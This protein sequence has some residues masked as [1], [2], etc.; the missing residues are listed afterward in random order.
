M[1]WSSKSG[2]IYSVRVWTKSLSPSVI[3]IFMRHTKNM[4]VK[5]GEKMSLRKLVSAI[6]AFA[7][8]S[9]SFVPV[10]AVTLD[11]GVTTLPV[12]APDVGTTA[13]GAN[14]DVIPA[15]IRITASGTEI[16]Y[17]TLSG[18]G[19]N[20]ASAVSVSANGQLSTANGA[21]ALS[22]V[23]R[24]LVVTP[25]AGTKFVKLASSETGENYLPA[26]VTVNGRLASAAA[27]TVKNL[28]VVQNPAAAYPGSGDNG[29]AI[30]AAVLTKTGPASTFGTTIAAG[31]V[32][33]YFVT[34][35]GAATT[36]VGGTM[37]V[38]LAGIG[39][40]ADPAASPT[41]SGTATATFQTLSGG[42]V[43]SAISGAEGGTVNIGTYGS[44]AGK[45]E[46]VMVGDKTGNET[47]TT[48]EPDSQNNS[49]LGNLLASG[50]STVVIGPGNVTT[51]TSGATTLKV[52]TDALVLRAAERNDSSS[53]TFKFYET[54]FATS[55]FVSSSPVNENGTASI[56]T[57][58][59]ALTNTTTF[60]N[61]DNAL[62]TVKFHA[63]KPGTTTA[64]SA[65]MVVNAVSV[66]LVGPRAF[67]GIRG[68]ASSSK[69]GSTQSLSTTAGNGGFLGAVAY[70][71][72]NGNTAINS[73]VVA[74]SKLAI[75]V[76]YNG[77]SATGRLTMKDSAPLTFTQQLAAH[78]FVG[79]T[80][81]VSALNS[82]S[83][84]TLIHNGT[85]ANGIFPGALVIGYNNGGTANPYGLVKT[86]TDNGT[87]FATFKN[88]SVFTASV[89][90]NQAIYSPS[91]VTVRL[92]NSAGSSTN[93]NAW[94][95][96]AGNEDA[97]DETAAAGSFE[98]GGSNPSADLYSN[99]AVVKITNGNQT[100]KNARNNAILVAR[101]A[102]D[103]L[104]IL[105]ITDKY[106][107]YRDAIAIRPEIT[108]TLD[109]T[110]KAE[111][112]DV[113][114]VATG[115]NLSGSTSKTVARVLAAG[116]VTTNATV[117][118]LPVSGNLT[119]LM[120]ESS[121]AAGTSRASVA[122]SSITGAS[123]SVDTVSDLASTGLVIDTT[124]PPLFCGGTAGTGVKGPNGVV[125]QPK[126]RAVLIT[127][128]GADT[129]SDMIALGSNTVIRVTLPTG[130]DLN[131]YNASLASSQI[132]GVISTG[133]GSGSVSFT[134][135]PTL[136]RVQP[137]SN[138]NTALAKAFVDISL[139][140]TGTPTVTSLRRAIGLV[141]KPNALVA[142]ASVS[143]FTATISLVN[144]GGTETRDASVSDDVVLNTIG[145]VELADGCSTFLT[146]GYC[147]DGLDSYFA[148]S[149][150]TVISQRVSNGANSIAFSSTPGSMARLIATSNVAVTLPDICVAEGVA[151]ALPVGATADGVPSA[152]GTISTANR[153]VHIA[154]SFNGSSATGNV[155]FNGDSA[156]IWTSDNTV[157]TANVTTFGPNEFG[158]TV[159]DAGNTVG[160]FEAATEFRIKGTTMNPGSGTTP[161]P[162][163]SLFAWVE[164]DDGTASTNTTYTIGSNTPQ[165]FNY[166]AVNGTALA[167]V[168]TAAFEN[169]KMLAAY[170][171]GNLADGSR[172]PTMS[173]FNDSST[174]ANTNTLTVISSFAA[175]ATLSNAVSNIFDGSGYT[176]LD[177]DVGDTLSVSLS[178]I[179]GSTDKLVEVSGKTDTLEPGSVLSVSTTGSGPQDTMVVPVLADGSF[180]ALVRASTSQQ[181]T[182]I[183]TPDSIA[184]TLPQVV[185]LAVEDANID[186]VLSS[187]TVN[188]IGIDNV[189]SKSKVAVVFTVEAT[190]KLNGSDFVPTAAQLTLGGQP[191]TAVT[192]ST[193][194][195]IALVNLNKEG[196]LTLAT[197]VGD[198]SSVE[199]TGLTTVAGVGAKPVLTSVRENGAGFTFIKG[200]NL[201][202]SGTFGYVLS[203]GTFTTVALRN[204]TK[205]DKDKGR[206]RSA[207]A[208]SIPATAV[209]A[210]F[211]S[212]GGVSTI[213]VN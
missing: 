120:V 60:P 213:A 12:V 40:A 74:E 127:E 15:N 1:T 84:P 86:A 129:F 37:Q 167:N 181:I 165:A 45:T 44:R 185:S 186:P 143:D 99:G 117:Q 184:A 202:N 135:L 51:T 55:A 27:G 174:S 124:V 204:R 171:N 28:T 38:K 83:A 61:S 9:T 82:A 168:G 193:T 48:A 31:S 172:T 197:T 39:L 101:L 85:W 145:T 89:V 180:K 139:G 201:K 144:T 29:N 179:T 13:N 191:V 4:R 70:Q 141:F 211:F 43:L 154:S 47:S 8:V 59:T 102:G 104:Q 58:N 106:D 153:R 190:G 159:T 32:V 35:D 169:G 178:A 108:L 42:T 175:P 67:N 138:G 136:A 50:S 98:I 2:T 14:R 128:N 160:P 17:T 49:V 126:A 199:L 151:D 148:N 110:S 19:V 137:L 212:A 54:A 22:A 103:T 115:G 195:F 21:S 200:I 130:W 100:T 73:P 24:A 206:R 16:L 207:S 149:S 81:N 87:G 10:S 163:Q 210:V 46:F 30:I 23:R 62:M 77:T 68:Q 111:G 69:G 34:A 75:G 3:E 131:A 65:T 113:I 164:A 88:G 140:A 177:S 112:V 96:I 20:G 92:V 57:L 119:G 114:A 80:Q 122:L 182:V 170:F 63:Y 133:N 121:T 90:A 155:G 158:F 194:K 142:P 97:G 6:L 196:A 132:L 71:P 198:G 147:D 156:T 95:F 79:A 33:I 176:K 72:S 91:E 18:L 157:S 93:T 107:G 134:T 52:D 173:N 205:S 209:Y 203:D 41:S 25:P 150:S 152:F 36:G 53:S 5:K 109:T 105:P 125:F 94:F 7:F 162:A 66:T 26:S 116:T 123:T 192:G 11:N 183:Q 78:G 161:P 188:D 64:S 208:A 76:I 118:A 146:V 189:T 187:A 166:N 56:A